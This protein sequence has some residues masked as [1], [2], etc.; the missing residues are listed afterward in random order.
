[1]RNSSASDREDEDDER[2][3]DETGLGAGRIGAAVVRGVEYELL[4]L[5][6]D[7]E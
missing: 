5:D 7:E 4:M 2:L 1:M 3:L 6:E